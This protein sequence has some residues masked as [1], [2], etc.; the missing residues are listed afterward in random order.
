M[1]VNGARGLAVDLNT[2][3]PKVE[4]SRPSR[5]TTMKQQVGRVFPSGLSSSFSHA[6][7]DA[8]QNAYQNGEE[9]SG[10]LSGCPP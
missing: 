2:F 9:I 7:H 8:Y 10:C 1:N 5:C 3:N 6:Y 4:G